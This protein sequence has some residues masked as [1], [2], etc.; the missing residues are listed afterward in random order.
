M[1]AINA[2]AITFLQYSDFTVA[3]AVQLNFALMAA[4][5]GSLILVD[6]YFL[7]FFTY[8]KLDKEA[9]LLNYL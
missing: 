2:V 6:G 8:Y 9:D 1:V 5:L 7:N 3:K 4:I